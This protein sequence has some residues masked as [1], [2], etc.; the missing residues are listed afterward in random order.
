MRTAFARS[1]LLPALLSHLHA[2][3][4]DATTDYID[5][6]YT[7]NLGPTGARGW[8][9]STGNEWTFAPEGLTTE[10]RQIK[11]TQIEA[12]S[13]ADGILQVDD[14]ILGASGTAAAPLAF[15]SDARKTYGLAIGEAEKTANAGV[16]KLL[17]WRNGRCCH[18]HCPTDAASDGKL[19]RDRA[20]CL[21][22]IHR[23]HPKS[24]FVP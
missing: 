13:P 7:Y 23:H 6:T 17:V 16:L 4:P 19:Q 15:T 8:I 20:V 22:E 3:P 10:S 1:A 24:L 14:V 21:P 11:V 2:A 9:Y 12:G 18:A 5:T